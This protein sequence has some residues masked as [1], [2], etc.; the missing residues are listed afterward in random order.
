[1]LNTWTYSQFAGNSSQYHIYLNGH[2]QFTIHGETEAK[3]V[4]DRLTRGD[5]AQRQ[6]N[7]HQL[8]TAEMPEG[9]PSWDEGAQNKMAMELL[10]KSPRDG[11]TW[12][13][14]KILPYI[15][16]LE[17]QITKSD[18]EEHD[19]FEQLEREALIWKAIVEKLQSENERL[20]TLTPFCLECGTSHELSMCP[21]NLLEWLHKSVAD[22]V[23]GGIR[24]GSKDYPHIDMKEYAKV[25]ELYKA[26]TH[27][28]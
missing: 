28:K 21:V 7:S 25:F 16:R 2:Y 9:L 15:Q 4:C 18:K 27:P 8:L 23:A 26:L 10:G 13:R 20:S 5:D 17:Y 14:S 11:A 3:G 19:Q 24:V 12:M 22:Q 6:L 1:M